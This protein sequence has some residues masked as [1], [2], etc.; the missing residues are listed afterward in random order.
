MLLWSAFGQWD[1]TAH[2]LFSLFDMASWMRA[3]GASGIVGELHTH[4]M[5]G[6]KSITCIVKISIYFM[7]P[8]THWIHGGVST[9]IKDTVCCYKVLCYLY[10]F[11]ATDMYG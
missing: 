8:M 1:A 9:P 4:Q 6:W 10:M 11:M 3:Q 7:D 2:Q 5:L